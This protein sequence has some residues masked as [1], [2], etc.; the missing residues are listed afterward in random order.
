MVELYLA[1]ICSSVPALRALIMKKAP[2][3]I[4]TSRQ[5]LE[6]DQ[7]P[8]KS[9]D[10]GRSSDSNR[11]EISKYPIQSATQFMLQSDQEGRSSGSSIA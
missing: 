9:T 4:G 3:I 5:H 10:T 1:I 6:A 2:S 8:N 7:S 11:I